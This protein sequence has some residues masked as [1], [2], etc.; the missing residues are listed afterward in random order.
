MGLFSKDEP[1]ARIVAGVELRCEV[2]KFEKFHYRQATLHGAVASFFDVE[3]MSPSAD[4]YVCG[5]CG[6]VHWFLPV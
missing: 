3:W 1:Q 2:C 6:Y 5:H 4:C